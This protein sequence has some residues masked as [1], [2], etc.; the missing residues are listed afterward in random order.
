MSEKNFPEP[1][2]A[3]VLIL[4]T[5]AIIIVLAL[6]ASSF[7]SLDPDSAQSFSNARYFYVFGGL[8]FL[9]TP[10]V[11]SAGRRYNIN[12]LFRLKEAPARVLLLSILI[13]LALTVLGDEMDRLVNLIFPIPQW[14]YDMM[15]P[16]RTESTGDLL[17]VILGGVVLAAAG[18]EMLFR[19]FLQ[20]TLENKGDVTRA[21]LLSSIT[22]TIIHGNPYW[23]IQIFLIGII[24]GYL[25]WRS[26]SILPAI[27]VHGIYNLAGILL[28]NFP[29]LAPGGWYEWGE[30][31]SPVVLVVAAAV[32]V[33][34][35]RQVAF[36]YQSE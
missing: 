36:M 26:N 8:V 28:I 7:I 3:L 1:V 34:S 20:V 2:E 21:V 15:G 6:L 31:V 33:W 18:E 35:I 4:S 9:V 14:I 30:H 11:Y 13:G 22:W 27:M 25:A 24:I 10:L 17:L 32:L 5:F 16:I 19:G 29:D 23:A 12:T